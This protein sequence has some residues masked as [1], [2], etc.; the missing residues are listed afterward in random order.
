MLRRGELDPKA[1]RVLILPR[2][3]ALGEGEAR[4]IAAFVEGGGTVIADLRP[5][6]YTGR[7]KP[8]AGGALDTLF[9]IDTSRSAQARKDTMVEAR[10]GAG[11]P[12]WRFE[13]MMVD[14]GIQPAGATALGQAGDTPV[15]L[16]HS[17]GRGRA[18]LLNFSLVS[19][20][21]LG[22]AEEP[23]GA[24]ELLRTLLAQAGIRS[25]LTLARADG[26]PMGDLRVQRWRN[27]EI[28]LVGIMQEPERASNLTSVSLHEGSSPRE[29]VLTLP[30][31]RHI[32]NLRTH[33]DL[34]QQ[35]RLRLQLR[36]GRATFLALLPNAAPMVHATIELQEVQPGETPELHLSV[37]NA[38]G[39]HVVL[40]T[41]TKPDRTEADWMRRVA[42]IP[43]GKTMRVPIPI[44]LNDPAGCWV[45]H[46]R[47]LYT[48]QLIE[49]QMVV[50]QG[51][52]NL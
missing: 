42:V 38:I 9:G 32:Y 52:L 20:P 3:E 31:P 29:F 26:R 10:L 27:G 13:K 51:T 45:V 48:D 23:A 12:E 24:S 21:R 33:E 18:I 7:L 5:G 36:P 1:T 14:P 40:V 11:Q 4:A 41:A 15:L 47:E 37:P 19:Y 44:A 43:R 50:A 22:S 30:V 16:T 6:R 39:A 28:E 34:G 17:V 8:R 35:T 49:M 2:A 25:A 46:V